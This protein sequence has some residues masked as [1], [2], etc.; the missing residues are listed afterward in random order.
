MR[1]AFFTF[2]PFSSNAGHLFRL[3]GELY[4]LAELNEIIIVCLGKDPDDEQ[5]RRK[6]KNISFYHLPVKFNGWEVTNLSETIENIKNFIEE[7]NP[8]LL[9]LQMEAWELMRELGETLCG[10]IKFAVVMHAMPFLGAPI[11]PSGDFDKDVIN[12]VASGIEKFRSDYI[13]NHYK[14]ITDVFRRVNIIANNKT[15]AYYLRTYFKDLKFW[16]FDSTISIKKKTTAVVGGKLK[17]DFAYMA[18]ME[19]GKGVEYLAEILKRASL[20]LSRQVSLAI[21]GRPD[22]ALS[23]QSLNRLLHEGEKNKYFK[24]DYCGWAD[25]EIKTLIL[26]KTGVFLYPSYYDTY[27]V[28][29][30]E[31]LSFGLPSV[32]WE[33]PFSR[34]NYS[35][36]R[37]VVRAPFL[38]FEKFAKSA[39]E[40]L[41]GRDILISKAL[42]F[43]NSF[44]SATKIAELDS[45]I[46]KEIIN[47]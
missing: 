15:V 45:N 4:N 8:N 29:L 35:S 33:A 19:S 10:E 2:A 16:T 25:E 46:Y 14:E 31:A 12:Y 32:T 37:A 20:L 47:K 40:M 18:R 11:N 43:I 34:I 21:M 26:P 38:N 22:D 1:L 27:A 9:V 3:F 24:I 41:K 5:T 42:D 23:R 17:Y 6:Y 30:Y 7:I 44:E 39:V 13:G 36:T 28:S